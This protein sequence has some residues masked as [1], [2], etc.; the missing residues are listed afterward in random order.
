M[1]DATLK[2]VLAEILEEIRDLS[3][4]QSVGIRLNKN[5]DYPYFVHEGFPRFFIKKEYSL[6]KKDKNG[7]EILDVKGNPLLECMCGNV[8]KNRFNPKYP[9]FTKKGSFWTNSTTNLLES[10]SKNELGV[11]RN[12]CHHNGYESVA[13]IPLKAKGKTLGLIQFNDSRLNKFSLEMIN[14]YENL[15]DQIAEVISNTFEIQERMNKISD[16]IKKVQTN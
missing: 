16:S 9:Y 5:G 6:C 15:A 2:S 11:T 12:M 8:L 13:L 7:Q 4:C 1:V 14:N 3:K 10:T